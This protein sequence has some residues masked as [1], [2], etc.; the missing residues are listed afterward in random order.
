MGEQIYDRL[1]AKERI[2]L[3]AIENDELEEMPTTDEELDLIFDQL[4]L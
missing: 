2:M 1:M 3:Q 4:G